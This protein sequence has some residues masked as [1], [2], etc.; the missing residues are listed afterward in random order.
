MRYATWGPMSRGMSKSTSP[1]FCWSFRSSTSIEVFSVNSRTATTLLSQ[2][3]S[4]AAHIRCE[5][6]PAGNMRH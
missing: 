5:C 2:N 1:L 6:I 3:G 4:A